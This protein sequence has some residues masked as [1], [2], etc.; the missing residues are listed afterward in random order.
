MLELTKKQLDFLEKSVEGT[1]TQNSSGSI[2]VNGDVNCSRQNLKSIP[3]Q[4]GSVSGCFYCH[5][6]QLTSLEF[7]PSSVSGDFYCFNN[8]LTS[9]EFCP[10]T[11]SGNF[12]CHHN[13]LTSL[14]FCPSTVSRDFHCSYNQLTSLE[15]CPSAVSGDFYCYSNPVSEETLELLFQA[16]SIQKL[17]WPTALASCYSKIP[18]KDLKLMKIPKDFKEKYRGNITASNLGLI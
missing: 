2:D 18:Q 5:M 12:S 10:S 3:V 16:R 1:Y 6:N 8:Q 13:Q 14:E 15:F 17:S 7:C 11:V 4:F 9:L